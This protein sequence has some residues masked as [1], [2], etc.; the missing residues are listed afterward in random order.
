MHMLFNMFYKQFGTRRL[1]QLLAPRFFA[2]NSLPRNTLVHYLSDEQG[3]FDID[4][5]QLYL[6]DYPNKKIFVDY[7]E[8]L[9]QLKGNPRKK[10]VLI[11]NLVRDFHVK[12]KQFRYIKDSAK[13]IKDPLSLII[14]N[15]SY[16][17]EIYRYA[18]T[19]IS[20]YHRWENTNK[21]VFETIHRLSKDTSREHFIFIK[22]PKDI[23]GYNILNTYIDKS[24]LTMIRIFDTPEKKLIL[25]LW[26]WLSL[27]YRKDSILGSLTSRDCIR[28]NLVFTIPDGR[29]SV[30]NLG[31]L[32]S[33]IK[34]T[35]GKMEES[36]KPQNLTDVDMVT[37]YPPEQIQKIFLKFLMN[38]NASIPVDDILPEDES[39]NSE[40]SIDPDVS[41]VQDDVDIDNINQQGLVKT[42]D[43]KP[44]LP[45]LRVL[46]PHEAI[47]T[48][49]LDLDK[50]LKEIDEELQTLDVINNKQL[51]DKGVLVDKNGEEIEVTNDILALTHEEIKAKIYKEQSI[52]ESL[53]E[54]IDA[55]AEFGLL[56]A[57]EYRKFQQDLD[58]YKQMK[59]PYTGKTSIQEAMTVSSEEI[60]IS[61]T[62]TVM[63]DS[64]TIT[65][66]S[67]LKSSLLSFDEDYINKVHRKDILSMTHSLQR[68]GVIIKSHEIE[69][70]NS[71]LGEYENHTIEFKP[72]D[73]ASSRIRFRIPK[74]NDDGTF[75]SANN[76]YSLRKQRVDIPIRK[77]N[78]S[79]I[80]LSSYYG[81]TFIDRSTKKANNSVEW[82]VKQINLLGYQD[83][84]YI[85]K[86]A[87][88]NV[89]DN[90]FKAPYIYNALANHYKVIKTEDLTLVFDHTDRV[91]A[92]KNDPAQLEAFE[93]K[94][95]GT[96]VGFT[97]K[98]QILV[99]RDND[100]FFIVGNNLETPAGNIFNILK[101]NE[102]KAPVDFAELRIFSKTIP[103]GV[104][105][106]YYLGFSAVL[107]LLNIPYRI[108]E[109]RRNKD[110][111][112][113]EYA[114]SFQDES[115]IFSR[116][117]KTASLVLGGFLD[118]DKETRHYPVSAFDKK[119]VYFNLLSSKNLTSIYIRE[120]NLTQQLFVD[121]ITKSILEDMGE[122]V[123]FNGLLI[124]VCEMLND[125]HH[126]DSQDMSQMRIRGYE[127]V[128]GFIYKE[129][130]TA[131]RAYRNKNIAG[132][133][134]IDI[135]PYQVWSSFMKDPS[136]KLMEDIN[137]IQNLKES[138]VFTHVGEGGRSKDGMNKASRAFHP[139]DM[140]IVSEAS[141]D[142]SDVGV[143]AYL[144]A[145]PSIRNLRGLPSK[146]KTLEPSSLISTSGLLAPFVTNDDGKRAN[147]VSIMN[148]HTVATEGYHQPL[149]RTGYESVIGN[150]THD[151]FCYTARQDGKVISIADKGIIV[152]YKDGTRKGVA[153]GRIYG[154]A[155]GSVYPHDVKTTLKEN[156]SFKAGDCIAYNDGFFEPDFLNPGR[157]IFKTS[158][159]V[160][161]ALVETNQ[162]FEDSSSI[163]R[164]L[165]DKFNT[166]TTKVKSITVGFKQNLNR[167]LQP[168]TEV[169][170]K[171]ILMFIEDEITSSSGQF[172][173]QSLETL[174][175]L[176]SQ[177]PHANYTGVIDK[178]EV[179]YHGDKQDMSASL[180]LLADRSDRSMADMCK[181]S[182]KPVI[183][184]QVNDEYRVSGVPLTL[185][186]AE[187]K[188]YITTV[189]NSS[190]G[191]KII[192]ANQM[193][194]V[195]GE[196]MDY[197]VTTEQGD[198][199]DM[200][201]SY[202]NILAR[203][204]NSPILI[205]TTSSLLKVLG[206]KAVQ[207]YDG[208]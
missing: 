158:M 143:N 6:A 115:Y 40:N 85:K 165:S 10:S 82:L 81:K 79:T 145:N 147:F 45:E 87:P 5:S 144:S 109:N 71:A 68:A 123:T 31:Y 57:A 86:I 101:L 163:S 73:G 46:S 156:S 63:A 97:N 4:T 59:D 29:S 67:M 36:L 160:K 35:S 126:P 175:R 206:R 55:N 9:L 92:F 77:I 171:D 184:G 94:Y 50:Q 20:D 153:L 205:G 53:R 44:G 21:T 117:Y 193:K 192:M 113:D 121:P 137:P 164:K 51:K 116:K 204:V 170:P 105:L 140:G 93:K 111:K 78:P 103:I 134:K 189:D 174:K 127:R 74:I 98:N 49:T 64:N 169:R 99:V 183:T 181:S 201:F 179:L 182:G 24:N 177:T 122:P 83:G 197:Q 172:D 128:S 76:R 188:I 19:P 131:I 152:E 7:P 146:E 118:F 18:T 54:Q 194:S 34:D 33:W 65:D 100:E 196:V 61:S 198:E 159:L 66:K 185:D 178:I 15:Y 138:E 47:E 13:L 120:L 150:R 199:I 207:L 157:V 110:L 2:L 151:M 135:S 43:Q 208:E 48:E 187:I 32:N 37:Q 168:G 162:T 190:T 41:E 95:K 102:Q 129:L 39:G 84:N 149:V 132:K 108:V 16:L 17:N 202:K 28:I 1:Q 136:I 154:K 62:K 11:R 195:I 60:K 96:V 56:T 70:D 26:K 25:E 166:K 30:V 80:S 69:I 176:G 107:K 161:V 125:Y 106:G 142:S 130:A 124:R 155:E 139:N 75:I 133:S 119:D 186:K 3:Q 180:K 141:V 89:F 148:S 8:E 42:P 58:K 200:F 38:L 203:V 14:I 114:I 90:H 88:A 167:V 112:Q 22:V 104:V 12:N 91:K 173:D 52:E 27:E 191:D 23:P 72:V